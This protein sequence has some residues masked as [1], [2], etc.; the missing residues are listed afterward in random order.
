MGALLALS[1]IISDQTAF[2]K[3]IPASVDP[4]KKGVWGTPFDIGITAIHS[5]L[6]QNGK[7]LSWQ[8]TDGPT[9][10]SRAVLW[11]PSGTLTDVSVPYDRDIFCAGEI[12]LADGRL[13]VIGGS[14]FH[15]G[16][17][18]KSAVPETD[19]FDVATETWSPGPEMSYARW[20][21]DVIE[22]SDG[23]ILAV[24]GLADGTTESIQVERYDPATNAFTTLPQTADKSVEVYARTV[25]L[26]TGQ[27]FMAGQYQETDLLDLNTNTWS[28]VGN[29]NFGARY[30]GMTVLLPGLN[31]VMAVGGG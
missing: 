8:S 12:H 5:A 7:V 2:A 24:G 13:M 23:T 19:F 9:G 27:M 3:D 6:L 21:P 17:G 16:I 28:S 11:D 31:Q 30:I 25:I 18:A 29:M 26:P 22:S 20:Y 10:G 14:K 15:A 1:V 4:A